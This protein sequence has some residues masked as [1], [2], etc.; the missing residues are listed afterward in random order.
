MMISVH[1]MRHEKLGF[2]Y[3][4]DLQKVSEVK[5]LKEQIDKLYA[6][7]NYGVTYRKYKDTEIIELRDPKTRDMLY[8]A[9]VDNHY[10]ASSTAGLIEASIS[11]RNDPIDFG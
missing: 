6:W 2:L 10:I 3:I 5:T 7:M 8:T 9:F 1:R 11:E 4:L